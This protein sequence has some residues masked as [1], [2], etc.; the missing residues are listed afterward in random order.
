MVKVLTQPQT[1]PPRKP[2]CSS[3]ANIKVR[4]DV[5]KKSIGAAPAASA[6]SAAHAAASGLKAVK[7]R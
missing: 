4:S 2:R 3:E 7:N 5:D 6:A 1:P